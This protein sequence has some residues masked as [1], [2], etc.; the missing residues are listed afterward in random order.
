MK[1]EGAGSKQVVATEGS[2]PHRGQALVS[3][4]FRV[5]AE[6][7]VLTTAWT[8]LETPSALWQKVTPF[9]LPSGPMRL[10]IKYS[11]SQSI[12]ENAFEIIKLLMRTFAD[13]KE[14]V[15]D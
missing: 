7:V 2:L 5:Q 3:C 4:I 6:S 15:P 9:F 10:I 8:P 14:K 12:G 1:V 11:A 13:Q